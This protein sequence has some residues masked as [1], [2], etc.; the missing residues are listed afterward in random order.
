MSKKV[1]Y[2]D[3]CLEL[4]KADVDC[5]HYQRLAA[6][7]YYSNYRCDKNILV[8]MVDGTCF[9]VETEFSHI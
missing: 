5:D 4:L 2:W 6:L 3:N 1:F 8:R 7:F 9:E